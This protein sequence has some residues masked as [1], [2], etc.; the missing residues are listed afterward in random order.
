[1]RNLH[2]RIVVPI[3]V[4]A[5]LNLAVFAWVTWHQLR[6]DVASSLHGYGSGLTRMLVR[7]LKE[8][9]RRN[10]REHLR[11]EIEDVGRLEWVLDAR[12]VDKEG[13]ISYASNPSDAGKTLSR[14]SETCL[15]CHRLEEVP[16]AQ[17][18]MSPEEGGRNSILQAAQAIRVE[19]D[20]V[21]CHELEKGEILGILV[22]DL[23]MAPLVKDVEQ[24]AS[25]NLGLLTVGSVVLLGILVLVLRGAV[26]ERLHRLSDAVDA[27][28]RGKRIP[29]EGG[30]PRDEID[31]LKQALSALTT[32]L[33]DRQFSVELTRLLE[34]NLNGTGF[35][36][37]LIEPQ[38]R[39]LLANDE[40]QERLSVTFAEI[41]GRTYADLDDDRSALW[42]R[43]RSDPLV[44]HPESRSRRDPPGSDRVLMTL[45]D[46]EE[47]PLMVLEVGRVADIEGEESKRLEGAFPQEVMRSPYRSVEAGGDHVFRAVTLLTRLSRGSLGERKVVD[48]DRTVANGFQTLSRLL[49]VRSAVDEQVGI[50]DFAEIARRLVDDF[51][52]A[53]P[54]R[55]RWNALLSGS[56]ALVGHGVLLSQLA[57]NLME[58]AAERTEGELVVF[59][60]SQ[61]RSP[62]FFLGIWMSGRDPS[63]PDPLR[64]SFCGDIALRFNGSLEFDPSY[65]I[66]VLSRAFP[67]ELPPLGQGGLFLLEF[68]YS[69]A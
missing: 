13:R 54:E 57:I 31:E 56:A 5:A 10:D 48:L 62:R 2:T 58:M 18:S 6:Q 33:G 8:S 20:C 43:S 59:L 64:W 55:L 7:G 12:V 67:G 15:A 60:Q 51:R 16:S 19:E 40:A 45:H 1:M 63:R 65:D 49:S 38:G 17:I 4:L 28:R 9:M 52:R 50:C 34:R 69:H 32:D 21:E 3:A 22:V 24:R 68:P 35:S 42:E 44:R 23:D 36:I 27:L 47:E 25:R 11:K 30:S 61:K 39:I 26:V 66:E 37:M 14:V 29:Y 46:D 53:G 41:A